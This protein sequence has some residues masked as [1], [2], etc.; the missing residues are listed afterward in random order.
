MS[1]EETIAANTA[2]IGDLI[3]CWKGMA[4]ALTAQPG[5]IVPAA[6]P[7]PV[8]DVIVPANTVASEVGKAAGIAAEL[9]VSATL[10]APLAAEAGAIAT[11]TVTDVLTAA[12]QLIAAKGKPALSAA[13]KDFNV[14]S[15]Q[16]IPAEKLV[17]ALGAIQAAMKAA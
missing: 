9:A 12:S 5:G 7:T 4:Q 17:E 13:L 3:A 1:L 15:L 11:A 8:L 10:G 16:A 2:A 6:S 14:K